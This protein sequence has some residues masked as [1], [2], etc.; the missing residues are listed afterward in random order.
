MP[1]QPQDRGCLFFL[2]RQRSAAYLTFSITFHFGR[3]YGSLTGEGYRD[4][5]C[6]FFLHFLQA[7]GCVEPPL[8][9]WEKMVAFPMFPGLTGCGSSA[10][11]CV[12][13]ATAPPEKTHLSESGRSVLWGSACTSEYRS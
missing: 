6:M 4:L 12:R 9:Q 11:T 7:I 1:L 3:D 10:M 13:H 8:T 5:T 2:P